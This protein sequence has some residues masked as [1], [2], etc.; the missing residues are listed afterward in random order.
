MHMM[1]YFWSA[2]AAIALLIAVVYFVP[3]LHTKAT[4]L[5]SYS[6]C[7]SPLQYKVGSIDRQFGLTYDDVQ[8][9]LKEAGSIWSNAERKTLFTYST[10]ASLTVNFVYDRRQA[11]NSSI[12]SLNS[13]LQE[14]NQTL[15]AQITQFKQDQAAFE[16]KLAAF[17]ATVEKYNAQGGAPQN[18]YDQLKQEQADLNAQG[19]A[20]NQRAKQL[21][22]STS[23]YNSNVSVLN[24]DIAQ[25]NSALKQQ[26]E[27]G[28]YDQGSNTITVYIFDSH[29]ELL[30]TLAHE[31]GHALGMQ[32]V[33]DKNAIM[34]PFTT[35]SIT[36]TNDDLYQLAY[37][38]RD[39]S[40]IF[41]DLQELSLYLSIHLHNLYLSVTGK[42]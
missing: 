35:P 19:D 22:L 26:P 29:Q 7:N 37:V 9:D 21:K 6:E 34:Y 4:Q 25:F 41:H 15:N 40:L 13:Q 14:N 39:Q 16:Q 28:L 17:N 31:F 42:S 8:T 2:I 27:E 18:V 36:L 20:L 38:C 12:N 10:D 30:H 32:H 23:D 11:L 1:K 3:P 24:N 33:Q 5:L